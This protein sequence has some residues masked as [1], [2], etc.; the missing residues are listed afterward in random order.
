MVQLV[1]TS[2]IV[3]L[4]TTPY[5]WSFDFILFLVPVLQVAVWATEARISKRQSLLLGFLLIAANVLFLYQR[6]LHLQDKTLVWF[7]VL[8]SLLY[9][10]VWWSVD[11]PQRL[12]RGRPGH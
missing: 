2:L 1:V 5:G 3:S 11:D 10:W 6:S 8:L 12:T 7:P 4:L 9:G